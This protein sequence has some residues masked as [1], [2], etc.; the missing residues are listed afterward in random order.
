MSKIFL[1]NENVLK[2]ETILNDNVGSEFIRPAI[3]ASQD[4]YLQQLIGTELLEKLYNLVVTNNIQEDAN[5]HYKTLI[6][7]YITNYLKYKVLAEI[8]IPLAYK[9]RSVGVVQSNG[10]NYSNSQMKDATLVQNHYELR[11]TFYAERL[12]KY[13]NT[14]SNL[15]PEYMSTRDNADMRANPDAYQTNILL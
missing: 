10:E 11:A 12:S 1:I 7:E 5:S 9:Y 14:N 13:L 2:S 15:Y 4:I 8:T 6:D 3:E